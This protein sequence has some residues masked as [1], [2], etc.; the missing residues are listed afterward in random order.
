MR[1]NGRDG[2][3]KGE[4]DPDRDRDRDRDR[5]YGDR[6][7]KGDRDR[8]YGREDRGYGRDDRENGERKGKGG[9]GDGYRGEKGDRKGDKDDYKGGKKGGKGEKGKERKAPVAGLR[10]RVCNFVRAKAAG[11][12]SRCDGGQDVFF[13]LSAVVDN[14]ELQVNAPVEFDLVEYVDNADKPFATN[15]K[16]LPDDTPMREEKGLKL[17]TPVAAAKAGSLTGA[18]FSLGG[19]G[20]PLGGSLSGKPLGGSLTGGISLRPGGGLGA[21]SLSLTPGG[22]KKD[23]EAKSFGDLKDDE[24]P[25]GPDEDGVCWGRVVKTNDK[26]ASF[27]GSASL[28]PLSSSSPD[29]DLFFRASDV[30]GMNCN[31]PGLHGNGILINLPHGRKS[32]GHK[33]FWLAKGD[34]VSYT[35]SKDPKGQPCAIQVFKEKPGNWRLSREQRGGGNRGEG[36]DD[37]MKRLL[38]MDTDQVLQNASL[39]KDIL[40]S[41]E[42]S[43]AHLYKIVALIG[44]KELC[45][46]SRSDRLYRL[47]LNSKSMQASMRTTIIKQ[48]GGKHSGNF[49]EDCLRLITEIVLRD[50]ESSSLRTQL[51]LVELVEA[52][53]LVVREGGGS[54]RRKGGNRPVN[55]ARESGADVL[56]DEVVQMLCCLNKH[57]PEDV[58]LKRVLGARAPKVV[59]TAAEHCTELMEADDYKEMPILP[60][61]QEM[62]GQCAF[63]IQANMR[64][65][66]KCDDYL[67]THFMLLRED[68]IEPLRAGIKLFMEDKHSPKDLHVYT[69]VKIV[70]LMSTWEGLVYRIELPKQQTRRINWEKS[71]QLM[72]GSLLC[73]SDDSF[74]SLIWAT[75]WRRD[76]ALIAKESQLD[77]RLPF[78]PVDDCL[79]PGKSFCCIENV[80][81]YFEA[82]RHVLQALQSMRPIDVPFQPTLLTQSPESVPPAFLKADNDMFNFHNVFHSMIKSTATAVPKSFKILHDWPQSL[83]ESLDIDPSQ[84]LSIKHALTNNVGL[85]QGPPGTGK[86]WVGLK[87]V[88]ALLDNTR[89]TRN[90]PMLVVCY[91]NHALDQFLEGIFKYTER[92]ARIGSRS[93][94]ETLKDRNLKELV[95]QVSV[96]KEYLQAKR[97]L[98]DRRDVLRTKLAQVLETIDRRVVIWADLVEMMTDRQLEDFVQGY[99]DYLDGGG[100]K[101]ADDMDEEMFEKM[102]KTWLDTSRAEEKVVQPMVPKIKE[103]SAKDGPLGRGRNDEGKKNAD[104]SSQSEDEAENMAQDRQVGMEPDNEEAKRKPVDF[105]VELK[106]SWLP[107]WE[108]YTEKLTPEMRS[109]DWRN[110]DL[111]TL[112]VTK[113]REVYRQWLLEVHHDAREV[114]PELARQLERNAESR[115]VLERDRKLAVLSTMQIVGMTT[116]AVSK[117]QQLLKELRPEIVIVEEAAEVLEA[118]ILTALHRWTQHVVLI[119]DHQQL[120]PSTAVYRLS[121]NF[122]L[123]V[124]LFERLIHNGCAHITLEQQRRMHP[125]VSRLMRPLYPNLRDHQSVSEYPE[126][127]GI[128]KRTYFLRHHNYE[129]ED[130]GCHSKLNSFEANLV[131]ALCA[132]LVKSGYEE[133]QI[134]VLSP[135]LGQ[136]R[137]IKQKMRDHH[138]TSCIACTAVDNFQGEENDIIVVSLVRSNRS[139]TM[140]FLAVENRINVALTRAKH[141]MFIIGNADMMQKNDLWSKIFA[142][143][144]SDGSIG[145]ALPLIEPESGGIFEAKTADDIACLMDDPSL[146][147]GDA[148]LGVSGR[149][150]TIDGKVL[151]ERWAMLDEPRDRG[152]GKDGKGRK[153]KDDRGDRRKGGGK[154]DRDSR[155]GLLP[156]SSSGNK[157][158]TN[159]MTAADFLDSRKKRTEEK[160]GID[161]DEDSS[162]KKNAPAKMQAMEG[163]GDCELILKK[164]DEEEDDEVRGGKKGKKKSQGQKGVQ[165][166]RVRG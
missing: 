160:N 129:D 81:I 2:K 139:G 148:H 128:D 22:A 88:Q 90:S 82:Y 30:V 27:R 42:F 102:M 87:I 70:G 134:T 23:S 51:P 104:D 74:E 63:E 41:S 76:E 116:T 93:K 122:H 3:G 123:D 156:T 136:V 29:D 75:V 35:P 106:N 150:V 56:P 105:I 135:Y 166:M 78:E 125:S 83:Q 15:V 126:V 20:K 144:G 62:L 113:R 119:G 96:E 120:R 25:D 89:N 48:Q 79:S 1:F 110:E 95:S 5:G 39:F 115:A 114:L 53:E 14:I 65:Y 45:E 34:E 12:I 46:D 36:L 91:T 101:D 132:H 124:S 26:F 4:R 162:A 66:E 18:T 58:E 141:G 99:K 146:E 159:I 50:N 85:I 61:S 16:K 28:A 40:D 32:N 13:E 69:G 52:Y 94:S 137:L 38:D 158:D 54:S 154:G 98:T 49:L 145:D 73:L 131:R 19:G 153:G 21:P 86:T 84:L 6:E 43:S 80:T 24:P 143:M 130:G 157:E 47:F 121:K 68:Y 9:K 111:W 44:S 149:G 64:T 138:L 11:W 117:Y 151:A 107:Y 164:K 100:P 31:D 60:T 97:A 92:I 140:G 152:K 10:G 67:Q 163:F 133:S 55:G 112:P 108:D 17:S 147:A 59:R 77:I 33:S 161:K 37:K 109:L 165:V 118:H 103:A 57:F 7:G 72:Y 71:K 155:G 8:G 142:T 127:M